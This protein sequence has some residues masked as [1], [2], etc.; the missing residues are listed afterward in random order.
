LANKK[1]QKVILI[2]DP[3]R[4]VL[5]SLGNALHDEGYD[6]RAALDGSKALEKAILV[7]PE[8]ILFDEDC[9]LIAAKKFVQILR[10]NP[11]TEHIPVVVMI[12]KHADD[13]V[14]WGYR[15]AF[16]RKP[17]NNDEFLSVVAATFRK[18]ATAEEVREEGREIEGSLGQISLVDLVQ[19]F[20][21]NRKTGL[22]ELSA[23]DQEAQIYVR[24]GSVVYAGC[25]RHGGEKALFRLLVWQ[26][27]TFAFTPER[28]A[29]EINIRRSTDILLL[30]GARQADELNRLR[31]ELPADNVRLVPVPEFKQRY[32]GLHPVTQ[33]IMNLLEFYDSVGSLV[34][35][36][37]VSDYEACRAIQTLI[38]KGVLR[39]AEAAPPPTGTECTEVADNEPLLQHDLLYELK[40]K[41]AAAGQP[42]DRVTRAKLCIIC[43]VEDLL[44][45]FV[46][47]IHKLP[48]MELQGQIEALRRGFGRLGSLHL[49]ENFMLDW[50]LLPARPSLRPLWHPLG[51][52]MVGGLVMHVSQDDNVLYRLSLLAQDLS[53]SS[54]MPVL[55]ISPG[56]P[57]GDH[58]ADASEPLMSPARVRQAVVQLL[59]QIGSTKRK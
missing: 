2:A 29:P 3:D 41:V 48:G 53:R 6:V 7:H 19:I 18:M 39:I 36:A 9:P 5:R 32:E 13:S 45:E 15:E 23:E 20:N 44:R 54:G 46:G 28:I 16:I 35:H 24:D 10:S 31:S 34:D 4:E 57:P 21:L 14:G 8:L 27:G 50:M 47:G 51:S 12:G 49:S 38:E 56:N 11:R 1:P 59:N 26:T 43:P 30:E 22:L 40:V 17:F 42:K 52:G 25:G 58:D 55:Q 37:R 33:E